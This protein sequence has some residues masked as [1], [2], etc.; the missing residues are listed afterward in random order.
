M[1]IVDSFVAVCLVPLAI[2]ILLSGLDDLVLDLA[3]L[4]RWLER[5]FRKRRRDDLPAKSQLQSLPEKRI[6]V[7]VPLWREHQVIGRMLEH[8]IAAIKYGNYDFFVG[9]YPNDTPTKAAIREAEQR[10]A[11]V[12]LALCPHD[13]PT[14]KG[15]CLNWIFQQMLLYEEQHGGHF[16][17]VVTHDAEDLIHPEALRWLNY[18]TGSY[19]MVQVPVLPLPTPF[20]KFT[21]GVYCDEFAEF[22]TKDVPVR[23]ML[24]G[25]LPSNGVGTGYSRG[26]LEKLAE[27]GSNRIFDPACLTEDYENGFRLHRLGFR[28]HFVP[29]QF[30][31]GNPVATREYFPQSFQQAIRQRTRWVIGIALQGWERHRWRG[32][33]ATIYWFWRDRKGLMGNPVSLLGNGIFLYGLCTWLVSR[34][35]GGSWPLARMVLPSEAIWI[36]IGTLCLLTL[37]ISVRMGCASRIYGWRSALGVPIRAIWGNWMNSIATVLAVYRYTLAR[38][39]NQPLVWLKTDHLYPSRDTL[40]SHKRRLG[41]I[42]VASLY[43]TETD[44]G[45]A[46]SSQP[47]GRRLGEHLVQLGKL[48]QEELYEALSLQ[49]NLPLDE[50]DPNKVARETARALPACLVREWD[51]LP[52]KVADGCLFLAGPE[53]PTEAVE[54][55]LRRFTHLETRFQLVTPNNFERLQKELL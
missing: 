43:L 30:L 53:L 20:V 33:L 36:F 54:R 31:D 6:A 1:P 11:N 38:L 10:F 29:I 47:P 18:Y 45:A 52:F 17:V 25:F 9:A 42:L 37:R 39:R 28:Q 19:D 32:G 27:T 13:G 2:L 34:T 14:S 8:N 12:H 46:L 41:E 26:A 55:K 51:V 16:Q 50:I 21:H 4:C 44:L 49:Q 5:C 24:G 7:F 23:Q 3:M 48:T 15:D 22:Q 35:T 40:R